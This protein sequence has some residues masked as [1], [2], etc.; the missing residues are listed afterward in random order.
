ME[1]DT[2]ASE[3]TDA[4]WDGVDDDDLQFIFHVQAPMGPGSYIYICMYIYRDECL[5][6]L[7]A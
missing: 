3:L 5:K 1:I 7:W 2:T 4:M 6:W